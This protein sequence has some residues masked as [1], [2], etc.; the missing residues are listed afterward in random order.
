MTILPTDQIPEENFWQDKADLENVRAGAYQLLAQSG[1]TSK[2]LLWGE[3]R[4]DNLSVND[5]SQTNLTYLQDAVLQ[6]SLNMFDWSGFY[7]GINYCNLVIEQGEV[8]TRPNEEVD[9]SFTRADYRAIRAE[10]MAL[11]S[12][13]YFYL[14]KSY[15][16]VPYITSSIRT[17][18]QASK[19]KPAATSGVAI[20]GACIDSLEANMAFAVENYGSE[21]KNK[22]QFTKLSV[23]ALLA[24]MYLWRACMLKN[25]TAKGNALYANVNMAN[26]GQ[27]NLSDVRKTDEQGV[28]IE[29]YVT[30]DGQEITDSYCN[31]LASQCLQK[32]IEH[33]DWVINKIKAEYDEDLS[34]DNSVVSQDELN[35]PYP[36]YLNQ[37]SGNSIT[38]TPYMYNFGSQNSRESVLELQYNGTNTT[39][40]TVNTYFSAYENGSLNAKY[41]AISSNLIGSATS[42]N[43]DAGFGKTDFRLFETCNYFSKEAKKPI[44]KF[45]VRDLSYNDIKDLTSGVMS[46]TP[47]DSYRLSDSNDAHWPIYRLADMML[48]KAEAIA[49]TG[50]TDRNTLQEGY[51]L[52]NQ[53]FKRNNPALVGPNDSEASSTDEE[54]ICDRV[55]DK[56]GVNADGNFEK[57]AADLLVLTY[58]ER[59]REFVCEG[60]RWFD[61]VRQAEFSNDTKTTLNTYAAV[62]SSVRTRLSDLWGFYIPIYNEELKVNGVENG[63]NLYQ[64]PVWDRYTKN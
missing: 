50:T 3:V 10:M 62:K 49:R 19:D 46:S 13:Y 28:E 39:N 35:Q 32:S 14:V 16:D 7:T 24:D 58:R 41:L 47:F 23:H 55:D 60:K 15:R 27:V 20:L 43:P 17:D 18:A 33:A 12:L 48:I 2:I 40:S 9:P 4:A 54:L 57:T 51:R 64:N 1:Q 42:V 52:V 37:K 11:R 21:S 5:M 44:S 53:L 22:G 8:M 61:L 30:A 29:G 31:T 34:N 38:D 45:V 26:K 6:P 56:Y 36:L 63:G 25:F 59:Q